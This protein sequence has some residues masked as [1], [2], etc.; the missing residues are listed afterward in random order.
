VAKTGA[1]ANQVTVAGFLVGLSC[2]PAI[3]LEAY[4]LALALLLLNRVFD[5]LDGALARQQG[6][7]DLGA[8]LDI[9]LDFI[10][11]SAVV[12][13]FCLAQPPFA[14]YGAFLIFS[15]VGSG[16][17]FL[18]F[19][20]LAEKRGIS[21]EAQGKKSI[22]YLSGIAE[23][24]ETILALGLMCLFPAQFWLIA[25]VFGLICWL[26]TAGRIATAVKTLK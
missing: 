18:A 24:F 19:A 12:F 13:G 17:A 10:V 9:V 4:S 5:G 21:T 22:Y 25:L 1:S 16:T 3:A 6:S 2:L 20:I 8:Y 23:G 26:S 7:T 15:F 11:Y 14:S